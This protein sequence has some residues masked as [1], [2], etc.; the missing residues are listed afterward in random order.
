MDCA[1]GPIGTGTGPDCG[2]YEAAEAG[3]D[4]DCGMKG[5]GLEAD[6]WPNRE[7]RG[8]GEEP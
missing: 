4:A 6:M 1:Q 3:A 5:V 7:R 2:S 8:E